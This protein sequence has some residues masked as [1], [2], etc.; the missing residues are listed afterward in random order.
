M[1]RLS[2]ELQASAEKKILKQLTVQE[3]YHFY[4]YFKEV[5]PVMKHLS[6]K[7]ADS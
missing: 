2:Q 7:Y 6:K 5:M 4:L 3:F 1:R